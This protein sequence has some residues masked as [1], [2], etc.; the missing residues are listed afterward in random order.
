MK[1]NLTNKNTVGTV[2]LTTGSAPLTGA[3]GSQG[4]QGVQGTQGAQGAQGVQGSQGLPGTAVAKGDQGFQGVQGS[5]GAQVTQGVQGAQGTPGTSVAKGDKGDSGAQGLQGVQ[6]SAGFIGS[7]GAQ[8]AQGFQGYQGVQGSSGNQGE[9]GSQGFQGY[10]GR[11]GEQGVQGSQGFQ[12]YQGRQG[13]QGIQ[14]DVGSKGDKGAT[15]EQGV[16]GEQGL[17]GSKGD[18]GTNGEQGVQGAQGSIG[19][20]GD[21]GENGAQGAQG[22]QGV[23][24]AKGDDVNSIAA[25]NQANAA[26]DQANTAYNQA[27]DAFDQANA[28][29]TQ[30][31][32]SN[33]NANNRVL[34]AGDTMTGNLN[35]AA[36]IISQNIVPNLDVTYDLGTPEKR[37]RDLYLS[38]QT[39]Y[40]GNTQVTTT[41]NDEIAISSLTAN[42]INLAGYNVQT[43]ISET[44]ERANL[45]VETIEGSL[46]SVNTSNTSNVIVA[47]ITIREGNTTQTGVV[48]LYNFLDSN[49]NTLAATAN[50]VYELDQ[51]IGTVEELATAA[52]D[53]IDAL[54]TYVNNVLS[55][56][57]NLAANTVRVSANGGSTLSKQQLNFVNTAD[58]LVSVG[59]GAGAASGNANVGFTL[60]TTGVAAGTYGDASNVASFTVDDKG[61]ITSVSNVSVIASEALATAAYNQANAAYEEANIKIETIITGLGLS[62]NVAT[63]A[64]VK[65]ITITPN[66]ATT[67]IIGVTKLVDSVSSSDTANAATANAVKT[68]YDLADNALPKAGGTISGDLTVSGNLA[69]LGDS[70]VLNVSVLKVEDNEIILNS[71]VTG[72]PNLNASLTVNRGSS[73]NVALRWNESTDKWEWTDDG[74]TYT[75][76]SSISGSGAQGAAGAQGA[77]GV[78]GAAGV[79]GSQGAQGAQGTVGE[80]GATGAQGAQGEQGDQGEQGATGTGAQGAQGVQGAAGAQGVQG[81]TGAQGIAGANTIPIQV[82]NTE[83]GERRT[84]DFRSANT[85][86]L[87]ISGTDDPTNN[88]VILIFDNPKLGGSGGVSAYGNTELYISDTPPGSANSNTALWWRANTG[89]FYIYYNDGDSTQWVSLTPSP[90]V[91]TSSNLFFSDAN[92]AASI[93]TA[94]TLY[95]QKADRAGDTFTGNVSVLQ[96]GVKLNVSSTL[97]ES[98]A[99]LTIN[100]SEYKVNTITLSANTG[101]TAT[102]AQTVV[103]IVPTSDYRTIKYLIQIKSGASYHATEIL[104]LHDGTSTYMT[105]YGTITSGP[106]LGEFSTDISSG[107]MRL[108]FDPVY[109]VN[110]LNIS[111]ISM[112]A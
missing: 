41:G 23:Q 110:T 77:Q 47:N 9:Q 62:D 39:I 26:Y 28:A 92:T 42:T 58:L 93:A 20:K 27:S 25:Y 2:K 109:A 107:N 103:D 87:T 46:L 83:I 61:R 30:A 17:I 15:G 63:V 3:S 50:T 68:V 5:I 51:Y 69:V 102:P 12:G 67:T 65:T 33:D 57:S 44:T 106:S 60:Q 82:A 24:G 8:G 7:N 96:G 1:I 79:Q 38:G 81:A 49:S 36:T 98:N 86:N 18:K 78:Q 97:I 74:V 52:V 4:S 70:T 48:Q 43:W 100:A 108:I 14:G 88:K 45:K 99:R 22:V 31:N 37:F 32:T 111:R 73:T 55:P 40:L 19:S 72:I 59:A 21:K 35:V 76:F 90:I 64:N 71:N 10:Q 13:E 105:E 6:G 75:A 34:R 91:N 112:P 11:Q 80:Q 85:S 29:Y 89:K 95:Q 56:T 94:N 54:K 104:V 53:E 16:Q 66:I 84:L 101:S